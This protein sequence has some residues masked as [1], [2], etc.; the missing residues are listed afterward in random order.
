M[1]LVEL[2]ANELP[3]LSSKDCRFPFSLSVS[4]MR[5]LHFRLFSLDVY[6]MGTCCNRPAPATYKTHMAITSTKNDPNFYYLPEFDFGTAEE[7]QLHVLS[8]LKDHLVYLTQRKS[9]FSLRLKGVQPST[10]QL[11]LEVQKGKDLHVPNWCKCSST[12]KAYIQLLPGGPICTTAP[13]DLVIPYWYTLFVLHVDS[14]VRVVRVIVALWRCGKAREVGRCDISLQALADQE[15]LE[16]WFPLKIDVIAGLP[17]IR[18][19]LQL[20]HDERSILTHLLSQIDWQII[21]IQ[22]LI[23]AA[24]STS[25][26]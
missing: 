2:L 3:T 17:C 20:I 10:A 8:K 14:N 7:S 11:L 16:G 26:P 19:R 1:L 15:V 4:V 12:L 5:K 6:N 21:N 22:S 25:V 9:D 18:L 23:Q 24:E 13:S